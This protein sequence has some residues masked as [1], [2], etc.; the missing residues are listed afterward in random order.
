VG[1]KM[2]K[3]LNQERRIKETLQKEPEKPRGVMPP[4]T[5]RH[6]DKRQE[7][8]QDTKSKLKEYT[9]MDRNFIA[10]ELLK[11]AKEMT[12]SSF[13]GASEEVFRL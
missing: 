11:A 13:S 8:R 5:I 3:P 9:S 6:K 1:R 7:K 12:G 2:S 10:S 4:P